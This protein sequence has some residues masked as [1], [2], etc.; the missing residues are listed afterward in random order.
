MASAS[1]PMPMRSSDRKR[2][3]ASS[4]V[5]MS[6]QD[7]RARTESGGRQT[8]LAELSADGDHLTSHRLHEKVEGEERLGISLTP[9]VHTPLNP[10]VLDLRP[11]GEIEQDLIGA[12][13][14][15]L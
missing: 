10:Q 4:R 11:V 8:A 3:S 15:F 1:I 2:S 13:V 14:E 7:T 9:A 6:F 12:A 5:I